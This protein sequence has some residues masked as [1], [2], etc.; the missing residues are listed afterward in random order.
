[1]S[2]TLEKGY[3]LIK[4]IASGTYTKLKY[5]FGSPFPLAET[6]GIWAGAHMVIKSIR[7]LLFRGRGKRTLPRQELEANIPFEEQVAIAQSALSTM[8]L[9][10]FAPFVIIC[11]HGSSTQNNPFAS[12]L[13]CGACGGNHGGPNA[14]LMAWIL[15]SE[16]VRQALLSA[17]YKHP[18]NYSFYSSAA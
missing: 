16:G 14:R 18:L 11:G 17:G 12:S 5:N 10:T 6:M 8:D 9:T 15:N 4:N 3:A 1:V 13:D 7:S 2:S